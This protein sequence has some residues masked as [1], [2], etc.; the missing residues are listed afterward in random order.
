MFLLQFLTVHSFNNKNTQICVLIK[1]LIDNVC[2]GLSQ[3][4]LIRKK[5]KIAIMNGDC[6]AKGEN[7]NEIKIEMHVFLVRISFY[8]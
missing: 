3:G 4:S 1:Q 8:S 6:T 7:K 2:Q 5:V